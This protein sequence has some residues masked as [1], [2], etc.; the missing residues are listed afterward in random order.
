MKSINYFNK[1]FDI[2][3]QI[4]KFANKK[5]TQASKSIFVH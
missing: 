3:F 2:K 4:K 5:L 1:M